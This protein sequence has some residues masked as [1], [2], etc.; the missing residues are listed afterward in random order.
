[1]NLPDAEQ[2]ILSLA[3]QVR[4]LLDEGAAL[5][6]IHSGGAWLAQRI[7]KLYGKNVDLGTLDISFYRDDF[8]R[9]GLHPQIK[10]SD[11]PFDV[12]ERPIVL[13]DDVLFTGRTVRAAMN[14]LFD[15]GR[16]GKVTLA[17]LVDRG[18]RE[19]PIEAQIVGAHIPLQPQQNL[20]LLRDEHGTLS[21]KLHEA[22]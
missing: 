16:P 14:E 10:P 3:D 11:I 21:L 9:I 1:M 19:L 5:V 20:H 2:L 12:E 8:S 6:G 22:A 15:Y 17:A 4:P 18:G 7:Q 13:V